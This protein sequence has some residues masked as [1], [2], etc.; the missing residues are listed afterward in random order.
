MQT[1]DIEINFLL[2]TFLE[3]VYNMR[4]LLISLLA[5]TSTASFAVANNSEFQEF[6]N[7]A[8][9]G[10][11]M[12]QTSASFGTSA[13]APGSVVTTGTMLNLEAERLLN[14][15]IYIDVLA[16]MQFGNGPTTYSASTPSYGVNGKVGY[17][18]IMADQHLLLTPYALAGL[19][20]SSTTMVNQLALI[21][22]LVPGSNYPANTQSANLANQFYY[23]GG[24][25]GRLEYR[26][27]HT[28]DLFADQNVAYNWDQTGLAGGIQPQNFVSYTSTLGARFN[29]APNFQLGVKGFYTGYDNQASN[30][31]QGQPAFAQNTSTI[32]GLVS[33]GMTY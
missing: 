2:L 32:G 33:V 29:L 25:G 1:W 30:T 31:V 22:P 16:N 26:I 9:V 23:T 8:S 28:I 24:V 21:Y 17:A 4:K 13:G 12:N 20:N 11:G 27:N 19:N 18:F 14:N 10:F 5:V 15:G 6:L 3:G 7:V